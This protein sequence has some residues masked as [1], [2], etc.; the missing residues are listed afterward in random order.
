MALVL[1]GGT[2]ARHTLVSSITIIFMER[3]STPG[4]IVD[5]MKAIGVQIRCMVKACSPGRTVVNT[6][7][8]TVTI[9]RRDTVSSYGLTAG[10]IVAN[11][12]TVSKME[13][14]RTCQAAVKKNMENGKMVSESDGSAAQKVNEVTSIA[15]TQAY[16]LFLLNQLTTNLTQFV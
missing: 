9:K 8:S 11:G 15:S 14:V 7:V 5:N 10:V 1:L 2:M 16:I 4:A 12:P 6:L 13:K 3:A